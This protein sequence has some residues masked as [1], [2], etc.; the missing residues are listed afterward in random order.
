MKKTVLLGALA[1]IVAL[2]AVPADAQQKKVL[3]IVVKGLD[4]PFFEQINLGCQKWQKENPNSEYTCL[5]TGPASS[6]DEAGQ[7]QV[8]DDLLTK[9]VAAIAISPSNAPAMGNLLK[10]RNPTIPVMTIDAD[11]SAGDRSMRKTYLGTDNYLMGV[12][13]AEHAK[14]LKPSGGTVCLQLGNV[15]A[16]NINARAAGFRDTIAGSKGVNRLTGQGGWTEIQGCPVFTNDQADLANKQMADTFLTKPQARR[17][18]PR[19]RMGAVRT[20]GLCASHRPGHGQAEEQAARHRRRRHA[21][22]ADGSAQGRPQ[23]CPGRPTAVRDGLPG[24]DRHDRSDRR[25]EGG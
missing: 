7:V 8:V 25:Q 3:A 5:Y 13:M 19:R 1:S 4:N 12:K 10:R 6:A 17:L 9:G 11:L 24:A 20:A 18:H 2:Y 23:S 16:D 15:A 14:K 21:A 22:A